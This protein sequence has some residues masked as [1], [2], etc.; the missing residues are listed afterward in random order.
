MWIRLCALLL[1]GLGLNAQASDGFVAG[2]DYE[3]IDPPAPT[4]AATG[5]IEVVEVFGYGCGACAALQPLVDVWKPQLG[6]DVEFRYLPAAFG[7]AWDLYARAFFAAEALGILP[8]AHSAVFV[9]LHT[10]RRAIGSAE[11][12]AALFAEHGADPQEFLAVMQGTA[13]SAKLARARQTAQAYGSSGTP[14]LIINGRYRIQ[15]RQAGGFARQLEIADAL[16]A[17]ERAAAS[18]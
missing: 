13:V 16:I 7:G 10:E 14:E 2:R 18:R 11:D 1:I 17:R 3:L 6:D 15:S 8:Q 9:A 12:I 4:S 5:K